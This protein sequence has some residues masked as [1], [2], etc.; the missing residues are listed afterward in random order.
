MEGPVIA[1]LERI[2]E[3]LERLAPPRRE[4]DFAA[5]RL[6]RHDAASGAFLARPVGPAELDALVGIDRQKALVS[7]AF[8]RFAA[9]LAA[10]HLLLWGARGV[11]KSSLAKAAFLAAAAT[12]PSL[13]MVEVDRDDL[14]RLDRLFDVLRGRPWRFVVFCDDLSFAAGAATAR[15]LK[16]ALEGGLGGP[17]DNILFVATSNRRHLIARDHEAGGDALLEA[18]SAD[19]DISV[20]DRFGLSIGFP[21]MDQATYLAAARV[22]AARLGVASADLDAAALAWSRQ[23]GARSG[24]LAL[25]FARQL[26]GERGR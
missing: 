1:V 19:E 18:E 9:R 13:R 6:F 8:G 24:R 2:A 26:A 7:D 23:R 12:A 15:A 20:S 17:P 10:N 21:P 11:G 16:S 25:Q 5:A 3:A 22:H 4:P 14:P